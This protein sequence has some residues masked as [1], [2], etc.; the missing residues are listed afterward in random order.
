MRALEG[1]RLLALRTALFFSLS[2]DIASTLYPEHDKVYS[3]PYEDNGDSHTNDL[4]SSI[5]PLR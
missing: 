5:T 1:S 2:N 4:L 3:Y